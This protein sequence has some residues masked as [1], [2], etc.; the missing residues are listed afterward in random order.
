MSAKFQFTNHDL[1]T[2]FVAGCADSSRSQYYVPFG[3]DSRNVFLSNLGGGSTEILMSPFDINIHTVIANSAESFV[4]LDSILYTIN[5]NI[6]NIPYN[7]YLFGRNNAGTT[8]YSKVRIYNLSFSTS[9]GIK[10]RDFTPVLDP[11]GVP[12]MYD[13]VEGKFY[14]NAGTGQFIAGPV[15][16]GE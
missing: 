16:G 12:C 9:N 10:I 15:I 11:D 5:S 8:V 14:Y 7:I 4:K 2:G 3:Y 1:E 6:T 13:K